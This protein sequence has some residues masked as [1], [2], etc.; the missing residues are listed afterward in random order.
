MAGMGG[1]PCAH[2]DVEKTSA[3]LGGAAAPDLNDVTYDAFLAND[4]TLADP[5]SSRSNPA[6]TCCYALSTA[7][8]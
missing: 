5:R 1:R 3:Y 7:R 6:A 8:R 2:G 4:R